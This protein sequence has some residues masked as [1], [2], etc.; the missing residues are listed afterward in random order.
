MDKDGS[1]HPDFSEDLKDRFCNRFHGQV[2]EMDLGD[3]YDL[4]TSDV[5]DMIDDNRRLVRL[6]IDFDEL[7]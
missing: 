5:Y 6:A 4:C 7:G 1:E 2:N 3:K